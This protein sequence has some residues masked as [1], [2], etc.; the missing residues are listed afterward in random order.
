MSVTTIAMRRFRREEMFTEMSIDIADQMRALVA[1]NR[2][3]NGKVLDA[4]ARLTPAQLDGSGPSSFGSIRANMTHLL[5]AQTTWLA[6]WRGESGRPPETSS[7]DE[8]R[9]AFAIADD[10]LAAHVEPL[11]ADDLAR[12]V[13][14]K[15]SRGD[16]QARPFWQLVTQ[17]VNHG[18]HHRAESGAL[19]AT[20][21]ASPGDM[22]FVYFA[23]EAYP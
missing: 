16:A 23:T 15:N 10:A 2:W 9:A 12:V 7:I 4:A 8:L 19:L 14:Y 21:D 5:T 1:Y 22:D 6:R 11:T 17:V 3:A 20:F 13:A 18:T